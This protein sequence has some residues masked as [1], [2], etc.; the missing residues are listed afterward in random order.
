MPVPA[1][2]AALLDKRYENSSLTEVLAAPVA[3]LQGVSEGDGKLL[4]QAFN[5]TTVADL[6]TS[7]Y[8]RTAHALA[9]LVELGAK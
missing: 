1:D 5:I 9:T 8:F 7:E 4:H 2:L 3:A 6:G